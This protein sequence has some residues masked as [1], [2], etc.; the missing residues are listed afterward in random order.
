MRK[1]RSY[2]EILYSLVKESLRG[3]RI[4]Y[5]MVVTNQSNSQINKNIKFAEKKGLIEKK[6]KKYFSTERGKSFLN[7]FEEMINKI[8]S[9]DLYLLLGDTTRVLYF[10]ADNRID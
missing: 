6:S 1:Y 2:L 4:A 3:S 9:Q 7:R 8:S 10:S 5:L